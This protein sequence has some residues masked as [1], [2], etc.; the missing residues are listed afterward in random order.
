MSLAKLNKTT[1]EAPSLALMLSK[2]TPLNFDDE[3]EAT[4]QMSGDEEKPMEIRRS[5]I[6]TNRS[7]AM[8]RRKHNIE[9][10]INLKCFLLLPE[11]NTKKV[12]SN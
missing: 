9:L 4:N 5:N 10:Y 3:K 8:K 6:R 12:I 1:A 7:V 11:L 2:S